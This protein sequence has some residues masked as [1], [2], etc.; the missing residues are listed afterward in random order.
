MKRSV[1]GAVLRA[2]ELADRVMPP[3]VGVTVLI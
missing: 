3:P 2:A 1:L